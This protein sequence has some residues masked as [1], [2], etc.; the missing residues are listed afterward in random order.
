MILR[1]DWNECM[2]SVGIV[3]TMASWK[4]SGD[5]VTDI[6]KDGIVTNLARG[7]TQLMDVS[8]VPAID[9]L[10]EEVC[11]TEVDF[12]LGALLGWRSTQGETVAVAE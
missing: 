5:E 8:I 2:T 7:N 11:V 4:R 12:L 1:V 10:E 3:R 9:G 6:T